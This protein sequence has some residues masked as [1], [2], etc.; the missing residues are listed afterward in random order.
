MTSLNLFYELL[1]SDSENDILEILEAHN[2]AKFDTNNWK[3][4]GGDTFANNKSIIYAQNSTP[5]GAL[6]EKLTNSVDALILKEA[7]LNGDDPLSKSSPQ[8]VSQAVHKYFNVEDGDLGPLMKT[9]RM[10]ELAENIQIFAT[11][12]AR[13][14]YP[15]I[16]VVDKGEG[17]SSDSIEDTFLSLAKTNKTNIPFVQGMFNQGGTATLRFSG[18]KNINL[19][20]TR[21]HPTISKNENSNDEWCFTIIK[22][23]NAAERNDGNFNSIFYYL[24]PDNQIMTLGK[25]AIKVLTDNKGKNAYSE[26]L[27][28]GSVVKL[29]NYQ[30][31]KTEYFNRGPRLEIENIY[32]SMP[33]PAKILDSRK[34]VKGDSSYNNL[35]GV[36]IRNAN[37]FDGGIKTMTIKHHEIGELK[38]KF[39][40]YPFGKDA[41]QVHS[42]IFLTLNGQV[43]GEFRKSII[44]NR[45]NLPFLAK[46]LRIEIDGSF[47][48]EEVRDELIT[49]ARDRLAIGPT[50]KEIESQLIDEFKKISWLRDKNAEIK[51]SLI[52][53]KTEDTKLEEA[54]INKYLL[55]DK[56]MR[57]L[58]KGEKLLHKKIRPSKDVPDYEGKKFPTYFDFKNKENIFTRHTPVNM[59]SEVQLFT[60]VSNDYFVRT[61]QKGSIT[62]EPDYLKSMRLQDGILFLSFNLPDDF[63]VSEEQ[64]IKI[65]I[66][67]V[68]LESHGKDAFVNTL[69]IIGKEEKEPSGGNSQKKHGKKED[70]SGS[71]IDEDDIGIPTVTWISAD[72]LSNVVENFTEYDS[73]LPKGDDWLGNEENPTLKQ[74][75]SEVSTKEEQDMVQRLFGTALL[76]LGL[77]LKREAALFE[78][79]DP[80]IDI[81]NL[82]RIVLRANSG[83]TVPI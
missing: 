31:F 57:A 1:N 55:K 19:I 49:T 44:S 56:Y 69:T 83:F 45:L 20:A 11:G 40:V 36:W 7:K 18:K 27:E 46:Y 78:E 62:F 74:L 41:R 16:T 51:A 33:L 81:D 59:N 50:F 4:F 54:F 75:K 5:E 29:Y 76:Y 53:K 15:C 65:K 9:S 82:I 26:D 67:D 23:F 73:I 64:I 80:D 60:D 28:Y 71:K 2:L 32:S 79:L 43:H 24:A 68:N 58:L 13:G 12:Y 77:T 17:Q 39:A 10:T 72:E 3:I 6:I 52:N 38:C 48:S 14:S 35:Y 47:L 34:H 66:S 22:K 25:K 30:M 21:K 61:R 70:S 42:G 8:T 63:K 37:I